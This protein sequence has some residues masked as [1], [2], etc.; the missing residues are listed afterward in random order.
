MFTDIGALLA[1]RSRRYSNRN[2]EPL[3][4]G[5]LFQHEIIDYGTPDRLQLIRTKLEQQPVA[6]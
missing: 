5:Y 6:A 4:R 1:E 2:I 3:V